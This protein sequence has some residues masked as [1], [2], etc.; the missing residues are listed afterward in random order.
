MP[1]AGQHG[2]RAQAERDPLSREYDGLDLC[3]RVRSRL[4][5]RRAVLVAERYDSD[6]R[7]FSASL[8]GRASP[9]FANTMMASRSMS[10][11]SEI[12]P[13]SAL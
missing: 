4:H 11:P 1:T 7:S 12:S 10:I 3:P 8:A 5:G 6:A 9:S 2:K 13:T